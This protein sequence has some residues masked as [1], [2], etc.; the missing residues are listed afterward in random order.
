MPVIKFQVFAAQRH[1][2]SVLLKRPNLQ[3]K[4]SD[5]IALSRVAAESCVHDK[6]SADRARDLRQKFRAGE[7]G[8]LAKPDKSRETDTR[9]NRHLR[10]IQVHC[11]EIIPETAH[12]DH[13]ALIPGVL[14]DDVRAIPQN[15]KKTLPAGPRPKA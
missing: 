8:F 12:R 5:L 3:D 9:R 15:K 2:S 11:N 4:I 14:K 7:T 13:E 1:R 6:R 10:S